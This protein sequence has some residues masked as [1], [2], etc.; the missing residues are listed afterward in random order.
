MN[1]ILL[2]GAGNIGSRYLSGLATIKSKIKILVI[3]PSLD[4]QK[5]SIKRWIEAGGDQTGNSI[6]Y[7]K[8]FNFDNFIVDIAI[9]ST[10]SKDRAKIINKVFI[11]T[12]PQYWIIEKVL[13]QSENELD[14]IVNITDKSKGAWVNTSRRLMEWHQKLKTFFHNQKP[15]NV[16]KKGNLWGMACN[17]IHFIDLVSWWTGE[18][19]LSVSTNELD[20]K[21][22]ESKRPGYYEI[23][24]KLVAKF[25]KGSQLTLD[26]SSAN[27]ENIIKV[28]L[29][30]GD[31]WS[32]DEENGSAYKNNK[33]F[34]DGRVEFQSELT[35][36]LVNDILT[37]GAC[38]LPSVKESYQQ[39][40]IFLNALTKHWLKYSG[41]NLR[42]IPIT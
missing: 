37:Y 17:S 33:I 41:S 2:V 6:E 1:S 42:T 4:A 11:K 10:S 32:I 5:L 27:F 35:P 15:L 25:S 14:L 23:T 12:K 8:D 13:A 20:R 29:L 30:N 19:L 22:F 21:W 28:S 31:E 36:K 9:V 7:Y 26:S 39:H 34:V 16:Y 18:S 24:G 40:L 3:E 38:S